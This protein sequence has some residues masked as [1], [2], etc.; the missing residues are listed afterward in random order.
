MK[1]YKTYRE[2]LQQVENYL[3]ISVQ[4]NII[5]WIG[6]EVA[7]LE[8]QSSGKGLNNETAVILKAENIETANARRPPTS[9]D[10]PSR[11]HSR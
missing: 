9:I 4:K 10:R 7:L 1:E 11:T 8:L 3:K 2:N 6:D 5:D